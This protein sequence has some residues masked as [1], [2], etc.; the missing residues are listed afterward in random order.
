MKHRDLL[1][2]FPFFIVGLLAGC[3]KSATD[4]DAAAASQQLDKA[5]ADTTQAVEDWKDY[6]F[7]QKDEFVAKMQVEL[8]KINQE[9]DD[10]SVK[11]KNSS[12]QAQA[13]AKPKMDALRA[14][15]DQLKVQLDKA[16]NATASTWDD[17]KA[18]SQKALDDTKNAF[19]QMG[20]WFKDKFGS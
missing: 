9:L 7:A 15:A 8:D 19:D 20:Q 3:S 18:G 2:V 16:K 4:Q 14:Q 11:I 6:T 10:L 17:V 12:E 1:V 13:D 5:K